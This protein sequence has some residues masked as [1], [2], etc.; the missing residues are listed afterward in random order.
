MTNPPAADTG[1]FDPTVQ[2]RILEIH[3]VFQRIRSFHLCQNLS[4]T[5]LAGFALAPLLFSLLFSY[6]FLPVTK[7]PSLPCGPQKG[8][9]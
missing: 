7:S 4:L 6:F 9:L 1:S 2:L 5:A 3:K 8:L